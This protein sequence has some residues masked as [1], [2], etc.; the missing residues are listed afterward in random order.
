MN[1]IINHLFKKCSVSGKDLTVFPSNFSP[2]YLGGDG[3][4]SRRSILK[5]VS[6]WFSGR[7]KRLG[8]KFLEASSKHKLQYS[9]IEVSVLAS[10]FRHYRFAGTF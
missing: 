2:I 8:A 4:K 3:K 5:C 7:G 10:L 9:V 6:V 1:G